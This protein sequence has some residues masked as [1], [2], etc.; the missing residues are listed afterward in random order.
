[1]TNLAKKR[2]TSSD[3]G[4][5]FAAAC[6]IGFVLAVTYI[7]FGHPSIGSKYKVNAIVKSSNQIRNGQPVRIAGVDIASITDISRGPGHTTKI[8]MTFKKSGEPLHTDAAL[9]IRPRLFL[10]GGYYVD[11]DAGSP[12][13]P[14]MKSGATIPYSQT[15]IP[16]QL[17]DVLSSLD[18][19]NRKSFT[20][21]VRELKIATSGSAKSFQRLAPN[22]G[23][24]L[25]DLAWVAKASRGTEPHD[26]SELIKNAAKLNGALAER[27]ADLSGLVVNLDRTAQALNSGDSALGR[28]VDAFN[29]V[30]RVA[31]PA[32]AGV[33][34]S[35]PTLRSF[36]RALRPAL[37][38]APQQV[39][40]I[41]AA[42][43]ELAT[44]VDASQRKRVV[45][46]LQT[47]FQDLPELVQRLGNLLP[48]A[49]PFLQCAQTRV[50][51]ILSSK[52]PDGEHTTG[53]PAY[54]EFAHALVGFSGVSQNFDG[55]G[56]LTR[57]DSGLSTNSVSLGA[58][59][60]I[61]DVL[62]AGPSTMKAR[63]VWLG[64]GVEPKFDPA[65]K[66]TDQALPSLESETRTAVAT[67][68]R[69]TRD[70]VT[71]KE[72]RSF[73]HKRVRK[74]LGAAK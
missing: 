69:A 73:T 23:P 55:N 56:P 2:Q 39:R 3:T 60:G 19:A 44:L 57:Y 35:L 16:V 20:G 24:V 6:L 62:S 48:V 13:A 33:E 10:E 14:L 47:T 41:R 37:P 18:R 32:L 9:K 4:T 40:A 64:S 49:R 26:V 17:N 66:C 34:A 29:R 28:T 63:P 36:S 53:Q 71:R 12:S 1:M 43:A 46:A 51:P 74:I 58:I 5:Y 8:E 50:V 11:L 54:M 67:P 25:R 27:D 70:K 21:I 45:G 52:V 30:L 61:G 7:A 38:G 42:L 15:A 31:P 72:L 68:A 65:A 59:P 22:L